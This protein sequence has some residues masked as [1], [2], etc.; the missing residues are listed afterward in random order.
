MTVAGWLFLIWVANW[1]CLAVQHPVY[2]VLAVPAVLLYVM[3]FA[4][5]PPER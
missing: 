2:G 3:L 4:P 1:A 5:L